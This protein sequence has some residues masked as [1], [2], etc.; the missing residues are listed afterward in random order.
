MIVSVSARIASAMASPSSD[1]SPTASYAAMTRSTAQRRL[2]AVGRA[3]MSVF[4]APR[5]VARRAYGRVVRALSAVSV[6]PIAPTWPMAGA[7]RTIISRIAKAA[8]EAERTWYSSRTSGNLRW[9]TR[10]RTPGVSRNGVRKPVGGAGTA[11][12]AAAP[13][14]ATELGSRIAPAA[15][16][17]TRWIAWAAP[18]TPAAPWNRSPANCRKKRRRARSAPS[19]GG[20]YRVRLRGGRASVGSVKSRAGLERIVSTG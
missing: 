20:A 2:T 8:S 16:A 13:P 7:P 10:W 14:I 11:G 3:L 18:T 5:N 19:P 4:A 1:R 9:S 17:E 12:A 6:S 15:S